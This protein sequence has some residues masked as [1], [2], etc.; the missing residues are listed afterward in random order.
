[1]DGTALVYCEGAFGTLA[2]K[3][4]HGLVRFTERYRVVGV[5]DSALADRD[6]GAVLD[7]TPNGVPMFADL[8][9][10]VGRS[11]GAD[12]LVLGLAPYGGKLTA[13]HRADVRR[14]LELS[15]NVDSGLHEFLSDDPE[16]AALAAARGVLIRDV[17][18]PP[19][20][21]E[22]HFFTGKIEEVACPRIAVLGTDSSIGKRT[23]TL[24]ATQALAA[25]GV[26]ASMVGTGQTAWLQGVRHGVRMDS[27]VT[28]FVTGELEHAVHSA[29][30]DER[31]DV[32]LVEGQ[33]SLF[34]PAYASGVAIIAATRPD[35]L[36]LQHVP[37]RP[38]YAGWPQYPIPGLERQIAALELLAD[39]P[40]LAITVNPEGIDPEEVPRKLSDL[41]SR[42]GRP[43]VD[44]LAGGL[45]R[46][47]DAIRARLSESG[48]RSA[49][50]M[51]G[52][53]APRP[54]AP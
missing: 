13:R 40:V 39:A 11:G 6:A 2:G 38:C 36:I 22:L 42:H 24:L 26:R 52:R 7:G 1:M 47:V 9:E 5:I 45:P 35:A 51:A 44:P 32:I 3:T 46:L 20:T 27:L 17:R 53:A 25:A 30:V 21:E 50:P 4:A 14:A 12:Y 54:A 8:G 15:L 10:A 23:T 49:T 31:P 37:E 29:F 33:G 18:K 28:D 48:G 19:P 43:V 41:E 34:H 16:L